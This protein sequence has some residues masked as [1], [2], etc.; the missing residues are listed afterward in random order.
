MKLEKGPIGILL[1]LLLYPSLG[2][3]QVTSIV[4]DPAPQG[5]PCTGDV[6]EKTLGFFTN[7]SVPSVIVGR[8]E[9]TQAFS[10]SETGGLF[11]TRST[12]NIDGP[13]LTTTINSSGN[14]YERS[15]SYTVPGDTWPSVVASELVDTALYRNPMN[16]GGDPTQPWPKI[17][18]NP[19]RGCHDMKIADI[20]GDGY[21]DLVCSATVLAN[22][23]SFIAYGPLTS[24]DV[25]NDVF[26]AGDSVAVINIAGVND[27]VANPGAATTLYLNP[28]NRTS[29]WQ[30]VIIGDGN[31]GNTIAAGSLNGQPV[32][33]EGSNETEP[34][35]WPSGVTYFQPSSADP[36]QPWTETIVD[37]TYRAVHSINVLPNG[38]IAGE[39][40]NASSV[41]N[42]SGINEHPNITG[43]R[44]TQFTIDGSGNVTPLQIYNLG[45][46]NQ[47]AISYQGGLLLAG[48]NHQVFGGEPSLFLWLIGTSPPGPPPPG[49]PPPGPPPPGPPSCSPVFT[50][51]ANGAFIS[52]TTTVTVAPNCNASATSV[53]YFVRLYTQNGQLDGG[54]SFNINTAQFQ[55]GATG[56]GAIVWNTAGQ[57]A[58]TVEYG[59]PVGVNV[60][61]A[62][63]DP[64]PTSV[65]R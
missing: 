51:P 42:K 29:V 47:D 44:V 55:N 5:I 17:I 50:A 2:I 53:G 22:T 26:A 61:I 37:T 24:A 33:Y 63:G 31:E 62:N 36:T 25:H 4:A 58:G 38:F 6:L 60:T 7:T 35:E 27:I 12:G 32:I 49:P 1:G 28:G 43:C 39:Q 65:K 41:C 11:L 48:A 59:G 15:K 19:S 10:C 34:V 20:D 3:A 14:F 13:W 18:I 46:H 52:G 23:A 16:T 45:T 9:F 40:E 64:I 30:G 56:F 54:P 8:G 21:L 57:A